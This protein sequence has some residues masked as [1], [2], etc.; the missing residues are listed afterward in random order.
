MNVLI[1]ADNVTFAYP[2]DP[3][4][5]INNLSLQVKKGDFIAIIGSNGSGKTTL[6]RL[7]N[8]LL[9]PVSGWVKVA[10]MDTRKLE[11]ADAIYATVGM[12]FQFPEDQIISTIVEE[13]VAFGPEN[14]GLPAREIR[15]RVNKALHIVGLWDQ[16]L[17]P[18]HMLSAGEIQRLALAGILAM[19]PRCLIFD[20]PTSMLDPRGRRMVMEML[21]DL[22]R[23]GFTILLITHN[24]EEA[25]KADH[26][27][28]LD[29][30][31]IA[32][33]GS[34]S[35]VF[36][37]PEQLHRFGLDL[38]EPIKIINV[39]RKYIPGLSTN[40][41]TIKGLIDAIP[42]FT[43]KRIIWKEK[44]RVR[45]F[46]QQVAPI[47]EVKGLSHIYMKDTLLAHQSLDD[48]SLQVN[49]CSS[50]GMMGA[51]GSGKS[52]LLLHLN[53]L[54]RPQ[55]GSVRVGSYDLTDRRVQTK[56]VT[57][58][59]GLVFQNPEM[60]F[61]EQYAGDEIAFGP[62]LQSNLEEP[63][64]DRV[65]W[66]MEM[67]GLDFEAYKD[68][69]M[70]S[71]SG[72]ERRKVALASTL[73]LKP[74]ILLL[75]EPTAGLDPASHKDLLGRLKKMQSSGM[76]LVISSHNMED[77]AALVEQAV[78]LNNG[79]VIF[80]GLVADVFAKID[81]LEAI[82][83]EPPLVSRFA[84]LMRKKNWPLPCGIITLSMLEKAI[85]SCLVL[86]QDE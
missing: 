64:A 49:K 70:F 4:K 31:K 13:D 57:Q 63:L 75:D 60:Q 79:K 74:D 67:V 26:I 34:P 50:L 11:C 43:G 48:I 86:E 33:D 58:F 77:I 25:T 12:V 51:T 29:H 59:V 61:F 45:T 47:I 24:M 41:L 8:G 15:Q 22:H 17:R 68:R 6:A 65:R 54:L 39:L 9:K 2:D 40:L 82:G 7:F 21:A 84:E 52:T 28:V 14:L 35:Q 44:A 27:I 69:F 20:E 71:L 37:Q 53:G 32:M 30:G 83:L 78:V 19:R 23:K 46:Q 18:S 16:R 1:E 80:S 85:A 10:G 55:S 3:K 66:A 36:S 81:E 73:A 62:R 38:P 72:G 56:T 76:T 5:I 42:M